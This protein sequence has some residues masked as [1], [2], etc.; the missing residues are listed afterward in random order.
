MNNIDIYRNSSIIILRKVPKKIVS[1]ILI[2]IVSSIVFL[3]IS[4]TFKYKKYITYEGVISN[5]YIEFYVD[6]DFLDKETSDDVIINRNK[7]H[8]QIIAFEEY[9]YNL[10][11]NEYWKI[12]ISADIPKEWIIENNKMKLVFLKEEK[13]LMQSII[14][15]IKKG[16]EK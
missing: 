6:D 16:L 10:G 15:K 14:D 1:W 11:I 9:S 5:N 2:L 8:Y 3:I 7:Y 12:V 13:T 4:V